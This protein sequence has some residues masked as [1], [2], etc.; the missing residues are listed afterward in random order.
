MRGEPLASVSIEAGEYLLDALI[1]A[2]PCTWGP[3][4]DAMPLSWL[5]LWA[6]GQAT[7]A[8]S[9]PWEFETLHEM[10][11]AFVSGLALGKSQFADPPYTGA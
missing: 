10:S 9:E 5:D 4:G 1:S 3:M 8:V 6:F 2:G 7:R 11:R